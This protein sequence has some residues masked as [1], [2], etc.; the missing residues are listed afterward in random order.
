M[1]PVQLVIELQGST[2][3]R[4]LENDLLPKAP[5]TVANFVKDKANFDEFFTS[6]ASYEGAVYGVPLFRGQAALFYNT[7]MFK[8][9]GL[10]DATQD[11]G[12]VYPICREADEARPCGNPTV[13]GWSL[14]LTG[15]GQGI[16]EKFWINLFQ[17]GG[18]V[19]EP[20]ADG[21]WRANYANE[22]G[23]A[24]RSSSTSQ[25]VHVLRPSR[26]RCQPTQRLSNAV[27]P[28]CS[29]ASPG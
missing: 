12:G 11:H 9:A 26:L 28:P 13:S 7:E 3:R 16:A 24:R 25:N 6:S 18:A 21:K 23:R 14:R 10:T 1:L 22:A 15:G 17:Y 8:A 5:D 27:R 19:L 20:T 4:Y 29:S 2:V